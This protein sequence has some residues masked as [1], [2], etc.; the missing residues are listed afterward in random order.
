[1]A[2]TGHNFPKIA[3]S[4]RVYT[5]GTFPTREFQGLNGAVTTLQFGAREVDSKLEMTF[6]NITD[7]QAWEIVENY[8]KVNGGRDNTTDER[9]YIVFPSLQPDSPFDGI[10]NE[11]LKRLMAERQEGAD[12]RYRYASP[13]KVT[14]VFPGI[15]TVSI[16][17]RGYL[18]A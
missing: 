18:E 17:L 2:A 1:M 6:K 5:P 10:K 4:Q 16:E 11:N 15:S 3:P 14:S 9:D 7:D 13:P 8:Q 12:L